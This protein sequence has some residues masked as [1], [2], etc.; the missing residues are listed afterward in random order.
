M[1]TVGGLLP[2][3]LLL[4]IAEGRDLPGTEPR[5]LRAA[6]L[7]FG[8]GEAERSW[9]C[10]GPLWRELRDRL[11]G[12]PRRGPPGRRRRRRRRAGT[13]L[14][15]AWPPAG[16]CRLGRRP[17]RLRPGHAVPGLALAG[18]TS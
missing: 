16:C 8:R 5:R 17:R 6:R 18:T 2:A 9:E 14:A 11:P 15:R 3:G 13:A 10:L 12:G 1:H 4:R 7:P